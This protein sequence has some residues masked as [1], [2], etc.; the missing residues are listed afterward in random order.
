MTH[1]PGSVAGVGQA[2]GWPGQAPVDTPTA[3]FLDDVESSNPGSPHYSDQ[4]RLFSRGEWVTARFCEKDILSS[5][6]L[7]IV[8]VRER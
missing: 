1:D 7:R 5:P 8:H 2:P 6:G 4:T 3:L